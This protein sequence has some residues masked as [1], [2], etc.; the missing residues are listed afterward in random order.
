MDTAFVSSTHVL[1]HRQR[2]LERPLSSRRPA[3]TQHRTRCVTAPPPPAPRPAA[4]TPS[5]SALN[6]ASGFVT[7]QAMAAAT[8]QAVYVLFHQRSCRSCKAVKPKFE[9][10][11]STTPNAL[12]ATVQ[13]DDSG[14]RELASRLGV[15]NVPRVHVYNG[16]QGKVND[17]ACAPQSLQRLRDIVAA[18][19]GGAKET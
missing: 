8:S 9:A 17:F 13:L 18:V 5:A 6:S 15:H 3:T 11:A 14:G 12:F 4:P 1:L 16:S 19:S 10:L 7:L 2:A